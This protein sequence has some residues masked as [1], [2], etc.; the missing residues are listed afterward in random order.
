ML[1][2]NTLENYLEW[3]IDHKIE[4]VTQEHRI[5]AIIHLLRGN[6]DLIN[7]LRP[8]FVK[9]KNLFFCVFNILNVGIF[10]QNLFCLV[11]S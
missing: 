4:T 9:K 7:A 10:Q 3:Y 2:K 5:V 11:I 6:Y 8:N 1:F